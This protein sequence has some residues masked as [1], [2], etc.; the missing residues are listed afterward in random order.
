MRAFTH[1]WRNTL[2]EERIDET[3]DEPLEYVTDRRFA[4]R[5]VSVGDEI[6]VVSIKDH[7]LF[8]IGK[9]AISH[10]TGDDAEAARLLGRTPEDV[11]PGLTYLIAS[12]ATPMRAACVVP[13][14][15]IARLRFHSASGTQLPKI[16][17]DGTLD[18]QTLRTPRELTE[19]AATALDKLLP[20]LVPVTLPSGSS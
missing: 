8:L 20:D 6:F 13:L 3:S 19:L 9:L 1:Y 16:R 4:T 10:V 5:G 15:I 7:R 18:P 2:V 12:R 17:P 14:E 11:R